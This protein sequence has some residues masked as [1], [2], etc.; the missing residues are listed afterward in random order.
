MVKKTHDGH[1]GR[2]PG[3]RAGTGM[4][5]ARLGDTVVEIQS[6]V[7]LVLE[8][9][10]EFYPLT[11]VAGAAQQPSWTVVAEALPGHNAAVR[12]SF[13]VGVDVD[14]AART[15]RVRSQSPLS[16]AVTTRK[17]VREVFLQACE[18]AGYTMI[19]ASAVYND[20]QM[21]V[22]AADKRGGK[23]TL[24]LRCV[25]DH[26]WQWL[27][28]DHLILLPDSDRGLIATSL[29]TPIPVKAG[30]L[31]DLWER[32]PQAWDLNGFDIDL[33]RRRPARERYGADEAAYF[34]YTGFGQ[35]N[36]VFV[37]LQNLHVSIVF[38]AYLADAT[39]LSATDST[40]D[41]VTTAPGVSAVSV[42]DTARELAGHLRLDWFD[43][44]RLS[45]RFIT[46][47]HRDA[48]TFARDG[49]C[50]S[51]LVAAT[52]PGLRYAHSGDPTT[53]L[54]ELTAVAS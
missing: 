26:G 32:L 16:L 4:V 23:T 22:F 3:Q 43:E 51:G 20:E 35:L 49:A 50:L 19:H 13:G 17:L 2:A 18:A 38:P 45:E 10:A 46:E 7:D 5:R 6:S 9:M 28:N 53:L 52:A 54:N 8:T 14:R 1:A 11:S 44:G 41:K 27:S 31:V 40:A 48:E 24:A 25:L 29:P 21:I 12:T 37:P 15:V 47:D 33:W 39:S 36:P 30:T 42:V 34:T